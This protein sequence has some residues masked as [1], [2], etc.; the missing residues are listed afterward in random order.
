[1]PN[2]ALFSREWFLHAF[3]RFDAWTISRR[4]VNGEC[5]EKTLLMVLAAEVGG[6]QTV[7]FLLKM[8]ILAVNLAF[9]TIG[10]LRS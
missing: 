4:P 3:S 5:K 9:E 6:K 10:A 8:C 7:N 1:M 2:S